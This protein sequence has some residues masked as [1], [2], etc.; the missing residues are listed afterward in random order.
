[1]HAYVRPPQTAQLSDRWTERVQMLCIYAIYVR[2]ISFQ[3][4]TAMHAACMHAHGWH[5]QLT[6]SSYH[7]YNMYAPLRGLH[8]GTSRRQVAI[9]ARWRSLNSVINVPAGRPRPAAM[10]S[11]GTI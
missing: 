6:N 8:S 9:V 1:M 10:K 3:T 11:A 2:V 4:G 5:V 7:T